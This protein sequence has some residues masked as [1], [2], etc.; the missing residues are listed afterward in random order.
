MDA[1]AIAVVW[2]R[3]AGRMP[4]KA[5]GG[6]LRGAKLTPPAIR[7]RG[8]GVPRERPGLAELGVRE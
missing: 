6:W 4:K 1:D 8:T 2:I 5:E 7:A 3:R